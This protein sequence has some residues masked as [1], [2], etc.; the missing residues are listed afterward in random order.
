MWLQFLN[1]TV[2]ALVGA[3]VTFSGIVLTNRRKTQKLNL[4]IDTAQDVVWL[5][6][7]KQSRIE[8][9]LQRKENNR[10]RYICNHLQEEISV[11][12]QKNVGLQTEVLRLRSLKD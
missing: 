2:P 1:M 8:Y 9:A 10:L 6:L 3:A 4:D 12:E 11:L 5:D 7:V